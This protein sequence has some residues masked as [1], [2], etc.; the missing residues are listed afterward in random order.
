MNSLSLKKVVIILS[1]LI[2]G[3][4]IIFATDKSQSTFLFALKHDINPLAISNFN[5]ALTVDNSSI[6]NF[7]DSYNIENI[8]LW[9]TGVNENDHDGDVYLNR[10]YKVYIGD[11]RSDID[12]LISVMGSKVETI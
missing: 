7:I 11:N 3:S 2:G 6:K 12:F 8:E 5:N 10:I 1:L 9:L 4:G